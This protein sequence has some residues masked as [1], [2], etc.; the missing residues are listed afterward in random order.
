MPK[1]FTVILKELEN[2]RN[3]PTLPVILERVKKAVQNP[4]SNA[5]QIAK[6][7]M[8]LVFFLYAYFSD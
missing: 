6:I 3:L 1:E 2:I 8:F 5:D 4:N 7:V